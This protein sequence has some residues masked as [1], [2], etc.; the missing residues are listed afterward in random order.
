MSRLLHQC[1]QIGILLVLM[2]ITRTT[3]AQEARFVQLADASGVQDTQTG[4]IWG[5]PLAE[6]DIFLSGIQSTRSWSFTLAMW[7]I[8]EPDG[9]VTTY[10]DFSNTLF[11]RQDTDWRIPTKDEMVNALDAGLLQFLDRSPALG[12]QT[13]DPLDP[14]ADWE[15]WTST[16]A[17]KV[18]GTDTAYLVD[19]LRGTVIATSVNSITYGSVPVRG[20]APP[21]PPTK[22]GGKK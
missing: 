13:F 21:P 9:Q 10:Q 2:G 20:V 18:R 11:G 6:V 7:V 12:F 5:Y 15:W 3:T 14:T 4:L 22:G 19:L 16:S 17:G 8:A 1:A